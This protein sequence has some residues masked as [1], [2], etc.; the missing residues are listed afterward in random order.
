VV[1]ISSYL[2]ACDRAGELLDDAAIQFGE[3]TPLDMA[4][5]AGLYR[6]IDLDSFD[7]IATVA[8]QEAGRAVYGWTPVDAERSIEEYRESFLATDQLVDSKSER[9]GQLFGLMSSIW[10]RELQP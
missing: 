10:E 2:T 7:E 1:L 4:E 9:C 5:C 8:A 3:F 6:A